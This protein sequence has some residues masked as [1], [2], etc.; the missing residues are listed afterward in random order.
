MFQAMIPRYPELR[1]QVAVVTGS[2]RNIGLGIVSRLGREGMRLV[3]NGHVAEEVE[4]A[5][6]GLRGLGCQVLALTCDLRQPGEVDRLF[7]R[8]EKEFGTVHVY[9]NNAAS[10][11]RVS[12]AALTEEIIDETLTLNLKVPLLASLRA[13]NFMR[14]QGGGSIILIS[15]VGGVRAQLPGL[16][17]GPSKGGIDALT[18]NLAVDLAKDGIRA[19]AV[20]PGLTHTQKPGGLSEAGFAKR[21]KLLPLGRPGELPEIAAV[22]AF[23]ASPDASYITGQVIYVDGGATAQLHPPGLP[24]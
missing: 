6:D 12:S 10:L 5:A 19:N 13:A 20:A 11:R 22:V 9:V 21:S 18:R 7:D 17:Y 24:F 16:P 2:S 4:A 15:S 14:S 8:V 3:V 23:L 1:G